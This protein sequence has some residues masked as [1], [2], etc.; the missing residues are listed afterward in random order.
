[1]STILETYKIQFV[2][3]FIQDDYEDQFYSIN[4]VLS[5]FVNGYTDVDEV[6]IFLLSKINDVLNGIVS[7]ILMKSE[8][9]VTAK[10]SNNMTELFWD[11]HSSSTDP[12]DY[13]LSTS[14]LKEIAEAWLNYLT[15]SPM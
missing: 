2:T 14:D 13:S 12:P 10:I 11:S 7:Q 9:M 3:R 5:Q 6:S 1:M 4:S 8:T 15:Q